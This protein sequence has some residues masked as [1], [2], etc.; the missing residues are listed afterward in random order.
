M[1]GKQFVVKYSGARLASTTVNADI[2]EE[3]L[4]VGIFIRRK[5]VMLLIRIL[6]SCG[7]S[8]YCSAVGCS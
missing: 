4:L 3:V 7:H 6:E 2:H 1:S 8:R 5:S